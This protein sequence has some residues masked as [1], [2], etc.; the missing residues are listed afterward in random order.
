M[1]IVLKMSTACNGTCVYCSAHKKEPRHL[2]LTVAQRVGSLAAEYLRADLRGHVTLI[3]HGGEP[4]LRSRRFFA[5]FDRLLDEQ[6]GALRGRLDVA[7][8][9][10][11]TLLTPQKAA[12]LKPILTRPLGTSYDLFPEVRGV[13]G[14]VSLDDRWYRALHVARAAGMEPGLVY[15]VHS[16]A[17]RNTE[18]VWTFFRNH[19]LVDSVRFNPLYAEGLAKSDDAGLAITA[20]QWG[21]FLIRAWRL[22]ERD[23]FRP[24]FAPF[25]ELFRA[26]MERDPQELSC[27]HKGNCSDTHLGVDV[28]GSVYTCGRWA[29]TGAHRYGT[30][31]DSDR[32]GILRSA[33]RLELGERT[34]RL[35]RGACGDCA[36][37]VYC[38]GGCPNDAFLEHGTVDARTRWCEGYLAFFEECLRPLGEPMRPS[39]VG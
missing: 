8:Q 19:P 36:W 38:H 5:A 30:V 23:G 33:V 13:K 31:F 15:V 26:H 17:V 39:E 21:E 27:V 28:D 4:L 35:R 14:C 10:N 34:A 37:W 32:E 25:A 9:S 20:E 6:L 12:A 18:R 24:S 29:D 22:Y 16:E 1:V 11:L 3:L 2:S 7:L